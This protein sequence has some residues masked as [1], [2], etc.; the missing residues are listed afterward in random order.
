MPLPALTKLR[1][2]KDDPKQGIDRTD[3][4]LPNREHVLTLKDEPS[5]LLLTTDRAM[6]LPNAAVPRTE[7]DDPARTMPRIENEEP[8]WEQQIETLLANLP[9]LRTLKLLP[10]VKW[11]ITDML[12]DKLLVLLS[13]RLL[14]HAKV[15]TTDIAEPSRPVRRMDKEDPAAK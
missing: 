15:L 9:M 2:E 5:K 1:R 12:L 4:W 14:P 11:L 6:R 13:E 10:R 7:S 8:R 3:I